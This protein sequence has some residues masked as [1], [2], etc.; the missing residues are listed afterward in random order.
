MKENRIVI[1]DDHAVFI[2]GLSLLIDNEKDLQVAGTATNFFD[3]EKLVEE[4]KPDL[5]IVDL[6]LGDKDGLDLIKILTEKN[7]KIKILV[8]SMM[9]ERYYTERSLAAGAKGFVMKDAVADTV[10]TAI[11]TV[12][13][14]KIWLSPSEKERYLDTMFQKPSQTVSKNPIEDLSNRQL[15]ILRMMGSGHGTVEIAN[16]LSIS[17][18]T[19]EAHKEQLKKKLNCNTAQE[20]L[21]LAISCNKEMSQK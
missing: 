9:Q 14:G 5:V 21:R 13:E 7:P 20:L 15:Q 3:G 17:T 4:I 1:I 2:Q 16:I 10:I 19:V 12:L 6:N 11:R 8:L 18:K